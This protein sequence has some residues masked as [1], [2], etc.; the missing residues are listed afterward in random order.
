MAI[1]KAFEKCS[2]CGVTLTILDRQLIIS[3]A[4][5]AVTSFFSAFFTS[6]LAVSFMARSSVTHPSFRCS[7]TFSQ[8]SSFAMYLIR[9]EE[10]M[11]FTV[12]PH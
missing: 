9:A 5:S 7:S 8:F 12:F 11:T 10:S 6:A 3:F 2:F 4:V 1:S